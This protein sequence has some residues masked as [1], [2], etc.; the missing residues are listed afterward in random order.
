M[1]IRTSPKGGFTLVE[2]MITV[3]II[4]MLSAITVPNAMK[5]RE[6]AQLH[7]IVN[8]LRILEGSKDQWALENKKPAGAQP[9]EADLALFI[10]N[11]TMPQPVV[12]ETYNINP[13][14]THIDATIPVKLGVI[15]AG[16]TVTLP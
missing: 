16:G 3:A 14:G 11:S 8:N 6:T 5:A 15:P 12:G 7:S 10:K 13:V 9:T 2:I 1:K 4:G